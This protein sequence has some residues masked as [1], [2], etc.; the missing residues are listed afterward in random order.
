MKLDDERCEG[1]HNRGKVQGIQ[2]KS[3]GII[4]NII[5]AYYEVP[6]DNFINIIVIMINM[7]MFIDREEE[8]RELRRISESEKAELIIIYGRR[9]V[10]KSRV[11]TEFASESN[12]I[13]L[14]ADASDNILDI[15]SSQISDRFV[16]F[17]DWE[18]FFE[19]FYGSDRKIL[20]IDEFQYLYTVN[21]AWPTIL[22]R[23]WE[24]FKETDKKIILCGSIITTIARISRG[25]GSAL[26][27]RK[28]A[29]MEIKPL[30]FKD[31][32]SFLP[33][34]GMEDLIRSYSVLG[35]VPR[36]I[37]EFSDNLSVEKNIREKILKKTSFLYNEPMNLL[38]EE[39]RDPA[40]YT[41]IIMAIVQGNTKFNE[42]S[43]FSHISTSKLPK[44]LIILERVGIIEKEIPVTERRIKVKRTA[45]TVK[46]NFFRFWFRYVFPSRTRIEMGMENEIMKE[47]KEDM[48]RYVSRAFEGIVRETLY[49]SG[50]YTKI[51]KWWRKDAEIDIVALN[52]RNKEILFGE[53]KWR[54][55]KI[56]CDV[57]DELMEKKELV[58][59]NNE[60]RKERFLI[61]SKSGFTKKCMERM[62]D[63]GI[64]HWDLKD[65]ENFLQNKQ[66]L[67][68][69]LDKTTPHPQL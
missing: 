34:Y 45:Y 15:F 56:G 12:A 61:V 66:S 9:R 35:G 43:Q 30:K 18:D 52:E 3:C 57:L 51:G 26:Y 33:S 65:I 63:E 68:S 32:G 28:T 46:D 4:A 49:G 69:H 39:F 40:P 58:K 59:W 60:N 37:E 10:G 62:D 11:L 8:I 64:M 44:Y 47:I 6:I 14:L 17:R 31:I 19:Y 38:F 22:Q 54:N 16:R 48:E 24:K 41:S 5:C 42:I 55:R 29:E 1:R 50:K 13:Y 27:G 23:W 2:E 20:I 7:F 67:S 21:K 53:V 25:Y 36:Y